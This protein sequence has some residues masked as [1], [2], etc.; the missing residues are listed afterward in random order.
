MRI[1]IDSVNFDPCEN[2]FKFNSQEMLRL[3]YEGKRGMERYVP[4][5]TG[6]LRGN[7]AP[8]APDTL[9]YSAE[10]AEYVYRMEDVHWTTLG[11]SGHWIERYNDSGAPEVCEEAAR[12]VTEKS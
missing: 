1:I 9:T 10:Y 5:D 12:I 4:K 8:S 11:T 2:A 6:F 7:S 3:V